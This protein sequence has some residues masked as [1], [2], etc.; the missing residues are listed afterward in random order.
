MLIVTNTES[1]FTLTEAESVHLELKLNITSKQNEWAS[2]G[3]HLFAY[4]TG[5]PASQVLT[6]NNEQYAFLSLLMTKQWKECRDL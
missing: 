4:G 2:I 5:K 6:V 3:D 1:R